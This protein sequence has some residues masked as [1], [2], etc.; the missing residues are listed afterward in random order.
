MTVDGK[1]Y[2]VNYWG[3]F[4]LWK[5]DGLFEL[6]G[7]AEPAWDPSGQPTTQA[8]VFTAFAAKDVQAT[9]NSTTSR[10][11]VGLDS[12]RSSETASDE[13]RSMIVVKIGFISGFLFL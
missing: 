2:T 8:T 4:W 9:A 3:E 12:T 6:Q 7:R 5:A 13:T 10:L 11:F 1:A